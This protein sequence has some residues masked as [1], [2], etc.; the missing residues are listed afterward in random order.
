ML[1]EPGPDHYRARPPA[2]QAQ[3]GGKKRGVGGK[4]RQSRPFGVTS[5]RHHDHSASRPIGVGGQVR[6][7]WRWKSLRS[8]VAIDPGAPLPTGRASI[9]TTGS[10]IWLA[11]VRKASRAP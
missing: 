10:T 4:I 9:R 6:S 5:I 3:V 11:E 2:A 7:A 8:A 1:T